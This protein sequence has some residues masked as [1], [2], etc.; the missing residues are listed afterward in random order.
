[1]SVAQVNMI[2]TKDEIVG[3]LR[4]LLPGSSSLPDPASSSFH[5]II[6]AL[7]G[8]DATVE[9]PLRRNHHESALLEMLVEW[10]RRHQLAGPTII[11]RLRQVRFDLLAAFTY[12]RCPREEFV[13]AAKWCT[14][15]FFHDDL[16]CDRKPES[17]ITT[18]QQLAIHHERM[19]A[20][21]TGAPLVASDSPLTRSLAELRGEL[22]RWGSEEWLA[23]FIADVSAH[24]RANEWEALNRVRGLAPPV[25]TYVQ[26]RQHAGA[27][28]TAFHLIELV[29]DLQLEE[30]VRRHPA[31]CQLAAMANNCI[32][33][34]ND[35]YSLAK[36]ILEGNPNNLVLA[37]RS[38]RRCSLAE[39]MALAVDMHNAEIAGFERLAADLPALGVPLDADLRDYLH[40]V[41]AWIHGNHRW[42]Q[43]TL[44]YQDLLNMLD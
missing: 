20:V 36:E 34:V 10:A 8:S 32:C 31:F 5:R 30:R 11:D 9:P 18:P 21:L 38:E 28:F 3:E 33:W 27:V 14:W 19:L 44:R 26:M 6:S 17:G 39:A 29:E 41:R 35:L 23:R 24:F 1:M 16:L 42:S 43:S 12:P 40:G 2:P 13:L 25:S 37:L 22:L 15:L 7:D 4:L